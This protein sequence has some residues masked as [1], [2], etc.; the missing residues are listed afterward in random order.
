MIQIRARKAGKIKI[1]PK[2]RG[3][4][5]IRKTVK[6]GMEIWGIW[7]GSCAVAAFQDHVF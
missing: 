5:A 7:P 2:Y 6:S 4:Y 3:R 1:G